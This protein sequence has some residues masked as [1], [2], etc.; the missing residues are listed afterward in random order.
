MNNTIS[1]F[2]RI[3]GDF[4][5]GYTKAI[6]DIIEVFNYV[7]DDLKF[8]KMRMNYSW[9]MKIL[10]CCLNNREKLRDDLNGFV[11]IEKSEN[12][13]RDIVR[14]YIPNR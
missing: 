1:N 5:R 6:K 2:P 3:S 13:K 7:N 14:Y 9:A 8:H 11:R 4:N 10:D 12:G